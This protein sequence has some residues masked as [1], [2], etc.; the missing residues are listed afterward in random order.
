MPVDQY[1]GGREHAILHL[2]Y[3]RFFTKVLHDLGM[4]DFT[5]PFRR[6][7]NQGQVINGHREDHGT[8]VDGP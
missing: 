1:I 2:L 8:S 7:L 6:L 5:E 4:I 3:T